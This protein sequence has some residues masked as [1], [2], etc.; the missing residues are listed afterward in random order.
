MGDGSPKTTADAKPAGTNCMPPVLPRGEQ[1]N[2]RIANMEDV[3]G[4][5]GDGSVP[6]Q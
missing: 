5:K 1:Q 4:S 3:T 2:G 6:K